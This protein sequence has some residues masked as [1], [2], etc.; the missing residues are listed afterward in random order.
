MAVKSAAH[1]QQTLDAIIPTLTS[2]VAK[3]QAAAL[4]RLFESDPGFHALWEKDSATAL[5]K[6]GVDPDSRME[7]G[8]EPYERGPE[9]NWCTTPKGNLCHC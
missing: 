6:A 5:K 9:C 7:M 8:M 2:P 1:M 4:K 3:T